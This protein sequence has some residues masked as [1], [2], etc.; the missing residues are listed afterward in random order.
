M[1]NFPAIFIFLLLAI[2]PPLKI[3]TLTNHPFSGGAAGAE[4]GL[5][6]AIIAY[7]SRGQVMAT[8]TNQDSTFNAAKQLSRAVRELYY[9]E[10]IAEDCAAGDD[11]GR[12]RPDLHKHRMCSVGGKP[13]EVEAGNLVA[14]LEG[15]GKPNLS[16][17]EKAIFRMVSTAIHYHHGL[18]GM[19]RTRSAARETSPQSFGAAL[20]QD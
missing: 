19:S 15:R 18:W 12:R 4:S 10:H 2:Y 14:R 1:T 7:I 9:D 17:I 20:I 16:S 11:P 6:A 3:P 13:T 8:E 5:A